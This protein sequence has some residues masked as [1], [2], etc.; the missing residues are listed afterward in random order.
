MRRSALALALAAIL[1]PAAAHAAVWRYRFVPG[2]AYRYHFTE[3]TTI[4]M[5]MPMVGAHVEHLT[6]DTDFAIR[7]DRVLPR[8]AYDASVTVLAVR[9]REPSGRTVTLSHLPGRMRTVR[10]VISPRGVFHFY[11]RIVVEVRRSGYALG[12]V[13]LRRGVASATASAGGETVTATARI[14]PRTGRVSARI[15]TRRARRHRRRASGRAASLQVLPAA[16]LSLMAL[17]RGPVVPGDHFSVRNPAMTVRET[18]LPPARCGRDRCGRL[19]LSAT[20]DASTGAVE[21]TALGAAP[22]RERAGMGAQM[23]QANADMQAQMGGMGMPAAM[24]GMAGTA[25]PSM[26]SSVTATLAFDAK[27]G[28][29]ATVSGKATSDTDA[30]GLSVQTSGSFALRAR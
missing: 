1:V 13:D 21:R 14:D 23:A 9:L 25:T 30:A 6:M 11:R 2:H 3:H 18:V 7:V 10:A 28:N 19:H 26:K 29:L 17:P 4:G 27:T 20:S 22:A 24:P 16:I 15:V 12:Y 5:R 8:G